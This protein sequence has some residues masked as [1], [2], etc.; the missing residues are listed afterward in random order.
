MLTGVTNA[1]S[2]GLNRVAKLEARNA[3][4]LRN[5]ADQRRRVRIACT[6]TGRRRRASR[7]VTASRSP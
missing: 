1:R 7:T 3:Y 2:E 5:P 4:G 6:R